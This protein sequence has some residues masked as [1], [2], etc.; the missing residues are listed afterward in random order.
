MHSPIEVVGAGTSP[1]DYRGRFQSADL[2]QPIAKDVLVEDGILQHYISKCRLTHWV[3]TTQEWAKERVRRE[4]E[5]AAE[6]GKRVQEV[7][8]ELEGDDED[9]ERYKGT[10]NMIEF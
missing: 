6:H 1:D 2:R 3:T 9:F 7:V 10:G 4:M 8:S 5:T